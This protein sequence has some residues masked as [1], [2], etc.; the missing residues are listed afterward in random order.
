VLSSELGVR[1]VF[2]PSKTD[3]EFTVDLNNVRA[4]DLLKGL[5]KLGAVAVLERQDGP[6]DPR[7][8]RFSLK[9]ENA[10]AATVAQLL[11][12]IFGSAGVAKAADSEALVSLDLEDVALEDVRSVLPRLTGIRVSAERAPAN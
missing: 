9:A 8:D 5:A 2:V 11:G 1:F 6:V 4:L 7:T 3:D 10:P 12:E